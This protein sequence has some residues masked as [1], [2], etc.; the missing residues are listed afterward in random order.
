MEILGSA[1][2]GNCMQNPFKTANLLQKVIA[3][4]RKSEEFSQIS[5]NPQEKSR[6]SDQNDEIEHK[7]VIKVEKL[8]TNL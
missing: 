1:E 4:L 5:A 2:F 7:S 3:K 6:K 8:S